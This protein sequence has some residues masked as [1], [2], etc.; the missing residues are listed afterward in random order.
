MEE[1]GLLKEEAPQDARGILQSIYRKPNMPWPVRMKA[2]IES[3]PFERPKL[4]AAA[5]FDAGS[6]FATRLERAIERS[7]RLK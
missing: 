7:S 5:M 3:L 2:A 4:S 6:D 1:E